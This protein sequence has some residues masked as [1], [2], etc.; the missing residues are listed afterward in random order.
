M[1]VYSYPNVSMEA[2]KGKSR[3]AVLGYGSQGKAH[4]LNL[5]DSGFEV[6]VG[7]RNG[8]SAEQAEKDGFA[9]YTFEEAARKSDIIFLLVPDT[10]H[11]EVFQKIKDA[12]S[13]KTLVLAHGLSIHFSLIQPPEGCDVVMV[14]PNAPGRL[15]R[16]TFVSKEGV[17]ASFAVH[18][19][20]SGKAKEKAMALCAALG[21]TRK[22]VFETTFREEAVCDL[23]AEQAV[24]CGGLAE[25]VKKSY[26][27]LV[28]AGYSK[29]MAYLV[30]LYELKGITDLYK[31]H[32]ID[33]MLERI[34]E[35]ARYG[36][37]K[38]GKTI[39]GEETMAK[40]RSVLKEIESGEF[41]REFVDEASKGYPQTKELLEKEK[42]EEI[43]VSGKKIR[44]MFKI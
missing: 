27:T 36:A 11:V 44:E 39:M 16:E 13:G 26:N 38:K 37:L 24:L 18:K 42:K 28:E 4:A 17:V 20:S 1:E 8:K 29:E 10:A 2:V 9:V 14:A 23:F 33:G 34:S 3:V 15:V 30:C 31:E 19:D 40:M 25:L 7:G 41:V 35:T 21:F 12:L 5:R 32:G 43:N 6:V 22:G